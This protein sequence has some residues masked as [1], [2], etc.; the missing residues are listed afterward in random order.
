MPLRGSLRAGPSERIAGL[1]FLL[2]T[3]MQVP[4]FSM[5]NTTVSGWPPT[6]LLSPLQVTAANI[7][8][9][10]P[11]AA[12]YAAAA[13]LPGA[14]LREAVT[15][16][17]RC[18]LASRGG[19]CAREQRVLWDFERVRRR[20]QLPNL[21]KLVTSKDFRGG[22]ALSAGCALVTLSAALALLV[23]VKS[24][25]AGF[26]LVAAGIMQGGHAALPPAVLV[27]FLVIYSGFGL[28]ERAEARAAARSQQ[29]R[30][31]RGGGGGGGTAEGAAGGSAQATPA[32]GSSKATAKASKTRKA[33]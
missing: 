24:A 5:H 29:R 2:F 16:L 10:V 27:A 23:T 7:A 3:L 1:S 13:L 14:W 18:R 17:L 6:V 20:V 9:Y 28:G 26:A 8:E 11:E 32:K 25:V 4:Y 19:E 21:V 15:P 33:A 12:P 22:D 30:V 31:K